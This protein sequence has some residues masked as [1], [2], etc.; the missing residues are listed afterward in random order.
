M[1]HVVISRP[2]GYDRLT[3]QESPDLHPAKRQV[4]VNVEYAGMSYG[5]CIVRMG[6]Y[7][8]AKLHGYPITPGFEFAGTVSEIGSEVS[9]FTVGQHVFGVSW[10][11]AYATQVC[12]PAHQ[13][14]AIPKELSTVQAATF[15]A[16]F[17]TAWYG[18]MKLGQATAGMTAL[19]HS[20]AGGVGSALA[21]IL[22][23]YG[24]TVIGVV[25][26]SKKVTSA[27][28]MGCREVIDKSTEPLWQ[29]A[30]KYAPKG[31]DLVFD[32]TGVETMKEGYRHL[33]PTGKLITYG[34]A[35]M[36]P[37]SGR[38]NWFM[39]AIDYLRS[40]RFNPIRM[41]EENKSVMAFNLSFLFDRQDLLAEGMATLMELLHHGSIKP[42]PVTEY[43]F[44]DV[45]KALRDIESGKTVGKLALIVR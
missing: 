25:G 20:A 9:G 40:P 18:A 30:K 37:K 21:Q 14:F 27:K 13:L 6:L 22:N 29:T 11:G 38:L 1:K 34:F 7:K 12:V 35:S 31:Y 24:C 17:L 41:A 45:A 23:T 5:E 4:V 28:N 3:I 36:L 19:V 43:A 2:G 39:L 10:F 44:T 26:S 42:L 15:P 32:S 16:A 33:A 8:S